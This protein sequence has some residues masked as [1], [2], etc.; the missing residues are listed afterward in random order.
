MNRKDTN[1]RLSDRQKKLLIKQL[2]DLNKHLP[3]GRKTLKELMEVDDPEFEGKDNSIQK[4]DE[5]E[6]KKLEKI[7]PSE[8]YDRLKLP[9]YI[10]A[11][12]KFNRG[13]YR[14]K[15]KLA[16][17]VVKSI[18]DK[19]WKVSDEEVFIYRPEVLK[20]RRELKTTTRYT[21][22]TELH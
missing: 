18:L 1:D 21:F 17:K 19:E 11:S 6:L 5:E 20:L 15:G 14:V 10:E 16:T 9:I 3:K 7:V 8:F 12:R 22:L 2:R 13:T 4:V